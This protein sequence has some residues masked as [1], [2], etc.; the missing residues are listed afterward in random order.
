[1]LADEGPVPGGRLLDEGGHERAAELTE[2][3]RAAGVEILT[4]AAALGCFDGLVA[5]WQGETL[6]QVRTR[7]LVFA[8]GTI[9][10]PLVF[11]DNDRP[12]IMLSGGAL[13][14]VARYAVAPGAR[15]V[16]VTTSDRGLAAARDLRAAGVEIA[17]VADLREELRPLAADCRPKCSP[18]HG[19][20]GQGRRAR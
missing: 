8:T 19:D 20:R 16:V 4:G 17:A 7:Q 11:A 14:L 13:A 2:R 18:P 5:V 9:E 10:Q 1:M 6:H 15:A 3:A 12:G